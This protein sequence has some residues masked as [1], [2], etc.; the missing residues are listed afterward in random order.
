MLSGSGGVNLANP[1]LY[2]L[3]VH[4]AGSGSYT[5]EVCYRAPSEECLR[6]GDLRA[7]PPGEGGGGAGPASGTLALTVEAPPAS[8]WWTWP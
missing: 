7:L 1:D 3:R 4:R 2:R 6:L 8:P 5:L